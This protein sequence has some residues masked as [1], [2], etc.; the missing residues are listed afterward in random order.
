[1][2][3]VT[4]NAGDILRRFKC[5]PGNI[6]AGIVRRV[7]G[8]LILANEAVR[9]QTGIKSRGGARGLMGRLTSYAQADRHIGLDAAIGFRKRA[10][11]FPYELSQ[12]F[13]ATA[14]PG[15]A[16]AIPLSA[17]ARRLS[18]SGKGPRAFPGK[19]FIPPHMHVLAEAYARDDGLKTIHYALVKSIPA[20]LK[21]FQTMRGQ[22]PQ[23][24]AAIEAGAQEGL[25]RT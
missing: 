1:M 21:F 22:L 12:E 20:R 13:G 8:A 18:D 5:L 16:M 2:A 10:G 4:T 11:G 19:L 3:T 14:K 25:A 9:A 23:I 17:K 15:K 24:S 6:Q 7:R